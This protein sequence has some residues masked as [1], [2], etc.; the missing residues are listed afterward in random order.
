MIPRPTI[1]G[2]PKSDFPESNGDA[3]RIPPQAHRTLSFPLIARYRKRFDVKQ[4]V[5][6][7]KAD[8]SDYHYGHA[9]G[10]FSW[11]QVSPKSSQRED[12][13]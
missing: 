6:K 7:A 2:D 11:L 9:Y 10:A 3:P 1:T 5:R 4:G 8:G 12:H 13:K